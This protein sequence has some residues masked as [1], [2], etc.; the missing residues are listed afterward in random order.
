MVL[1]GGVSGIV[2][3]DGVAGGVTG[4]V[5]APFPSTAV[6]GSG[7]AFPIPLVAGTSLVVCAGCVIAG[8]AF[9]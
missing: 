5:G 4:C 3:V 6:D 8:G 1:T 2:V 9:W 7:G